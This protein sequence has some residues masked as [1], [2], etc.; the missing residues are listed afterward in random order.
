[1]PNDQYVAL[2]DGTYVQIPA[3][4]TSD[5]LNQFR[6][7]LAAR[8]PQRPSEADQAAAI[9]GPTMQQARSQA[10]PAEL[11][12]QSR[13][14]Q[15]SMGGP[16]QFV[17]VP[18]DERQAFEQAGQRGYQ[19]GGKAGAA[20]TLGLPSAVMAPV[21]TALGIAGGVG[22]G[23]L[24]KKGAQKLGADQD[25]Q[26]ISEGVGGVAGGA[27]GGALGAGTRAAARSLLFNQNRFQPTRPLELGVRW[28]AGQPESTPEQVMQDS[29]DRAVR[30]ALLL[31]GAKAQAGLG[32]PVGSPQQEAGWSPAVTR[33]PIR[34]EPTSPL[35]PQ[36]VPGPDT[37]GKGNILTPLAKRGDPRAA[38]E[39]TRRGRMV[40]YT[41]D[42]TDYL[43]AQKFQDLL[44]GIRDILK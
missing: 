19:T 35:T 20:V 38:E 16:P 2:P 4:A 39:L 22:G 31:Q 40:L 24:A 12:Q 32:A 26:D 3:G 9:A 27:A 8:F 33:V 10:V 43:D 1:M 13:A 11:R 34:Q 23:Y 14:I 25:I 21:S 37:S 41:Q 6:A 18:S 30:R 15:Q 7:K 42:P 36:S 28:L 44:A 17:D 5:Q 29:V